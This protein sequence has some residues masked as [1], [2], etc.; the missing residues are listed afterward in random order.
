[1]GGG[2]VQTRAA[3]VY[4]GI[5]AA[6]WETETIKYIP[7]NYS[8]TVHLE[9]LPRV[10]HNRQTRNT[11]EEA[12]VCIHFQNCYYRTCINIYIYVYSSV[13]H[14]VLFNVD[15]VIGLRSSYSHEEE[16]QIGKTLLQTHQ[17]E[18]VGLDIVTVYTVDRNIKYY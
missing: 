13:L 15:S 4:S 18:S 12:C 16:C 7:L 14:V 9:I 1:M 5:H 10:I 17:E 2:A 3:G 6:G 11:E 8:C